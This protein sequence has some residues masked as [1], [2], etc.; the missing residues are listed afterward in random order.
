MWCSV[1]ELPQSSHLFFAAIGKVKNFTRQKKIMFG[2]S[3]ASVSS[4]QLL[5]A[6]F[7]QSCPSSLKKREEE[8]VTYP[9]QKQHFCETFRV[10]FVSRKVSSPEVFCHRFWFKL[11]AYQ[12]PQ[13][14]PCLRQKIHR[15]TDLNIQILLLVD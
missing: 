13:L 3:I 11:P 6:C 4:Y 12:I 15:R 8:E 14:R 5:R 7:S 9:T 2:Q 10:C 1:N